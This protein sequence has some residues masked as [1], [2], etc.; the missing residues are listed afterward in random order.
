V[1]GVSTGL[2]G[3]AVGTNAV[4]AYFDEIS[5]IATGL[6]VDNIFKNSFE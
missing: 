4:D 6:E 3:D 1:L 2:D 5:L